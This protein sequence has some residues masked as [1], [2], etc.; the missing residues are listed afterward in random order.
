SAIYNFKLGKK[1]RANLGLS[2]WNLF[3]TKND[4]NIFYRITT[5]GEVEAIIQNSLGITPN[6]TFRVYF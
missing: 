5:L 1:T 6:A 3:D 2:V 4:I